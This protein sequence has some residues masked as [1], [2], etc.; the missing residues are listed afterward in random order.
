MPAKG[1]EVEIAQVTAASHQFEAK[2]GAAQQ[3]LRV[4][5]LVGENEQLGRRKIGAK[6]LD[7]RKVVAVLADAHVTIV[8]APDMDGDGV[9]ALRDPRRDSSWYRGL[10]ARRQLGVCRTRDSRVEQCFALPVSVQHEAFRIRGQ[11]DCILQG[12]DLALLEPIPAVSR[13]LRH[14]HVPRIGYEVP[15]RRAVAVGVDAEKADIRS[16]V[17]SHPAGQAV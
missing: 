8:A 13:D 1:H 12:P 10:R 3:V 16:Q 15:D 14:G 17:R 6:M 7:R 11:V 2:A 9:G 5:R 4:I